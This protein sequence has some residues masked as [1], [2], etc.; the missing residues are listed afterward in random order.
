MTLATSVVVSS[1]NQPRALRLG[2]EGLLRQS[3]TPGEIL[4]ADDG[5]EEDTRLLV[6]SF[7]GRAPCPVR[8]VTQEHRG[9]GK[10][11]ALNA[12]LRVAR[13]ETVAFLDGDCIPHREWLEAHATGL[14]ARG[15]Y[16]VGGY[17]RLTLAQ[18]EAIEAGRVESDDFL[19]ASL[20]RRF[21][22]FHLLQ[23]VYIGLRKRKKPKIK[24]GNWA[25]TME[26]LLRVNGFDERFDGYGRSDT[27]I[28][29]RL[30]AAGVRAA[31]AWDRAF[32]F[33]C[34]H[35]MDPR[36]VEASARRRVPDWDIHREGRARP[37]CERGL[38]GPSTPA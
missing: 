7:G 10:A 11:R 14:R 19:D 21:R 23:K 32:V 8:F 4:I 30:N 38:V 25:A 1:Y 35:V 17:V 31:S 27:D 5:S 33:H 13:G 36:R 9:F 2:L 12:A 34:P 3:Q 24:G 22:W 28:R 26:A 6:A 29:N 16:S 18:A 37:R 15:G 20:R